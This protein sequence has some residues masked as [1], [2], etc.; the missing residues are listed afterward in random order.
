MTDCFKMT[1]VSA[2]IY[3]CSYQSSFHK[4]NTCYSQGKQLAQNKQN[5]ILSR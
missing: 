2:R 1:F 5:G 4:A 3:G